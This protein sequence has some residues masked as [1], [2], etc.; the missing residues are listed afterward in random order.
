[1]SRESEKALELM[2]KMP[3]VP[4]TTRKSSDEW[5]PVSERKRRE[6]EEK[7]RLNDIAK[8]LDMLVQTHISRTEA[9]RITGVEGDSWELV[10][11][12]DFE[13][14]QG[15]FEYSVNVGSTSPR[16]PQ[17]ERAQF[18]AFLSQVITQLPEI[19]QAPN[20]LKSLLEKFGIEDSISTEELKHVGQMINGF[21]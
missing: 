10:K 12:E 1:M 15:E 16:I 21:G 13:A 4:T 20:L 8:K 14:I 17:V 7:K 6:R 3:M 11:E 5:I 9:I 19:T 18:I 2:M